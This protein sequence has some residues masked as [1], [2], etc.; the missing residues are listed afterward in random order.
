MALFSKSMWGSKGIANEMLIP[1]MLMVKLLVL[2]GP[3]LHILILGWIMLSLHVV[4]KYIHTDGMSSDKALS[5]LTPLE[6][7][8]ITT[9]TVG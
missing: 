5:V 7:E 6:K 2:V 1:F 8:S 3:E 4:P 9:K